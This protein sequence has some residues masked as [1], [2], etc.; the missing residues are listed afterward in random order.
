M[1]VDRVEERD[2]EKVVSLRSG[3]GDR[4][5][6]SMVITA[7]LVADELL[8]AAG[9]QANTAELDLAKAGVRS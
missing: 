5:R 9:I 2:G 7:D 4:D 8:L 1:T 6:H 3:H